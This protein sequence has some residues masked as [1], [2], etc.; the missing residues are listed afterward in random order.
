MF[1]FRLEFRY[2]SPIHRV[3]G[4]NFRQPY[5]IVIQLLSDLV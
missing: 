5:P 2:A 4:V 3:S 1:N